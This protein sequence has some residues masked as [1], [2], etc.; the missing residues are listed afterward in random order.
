MCS[1]VTMKLKNEKMT[2]SQSK[3]EPR[4]TT[5]T[6]PLGS[7]WNFIN[8]ENLNSVKES[9]RDGVFASMVTCVS[10][11]KTATRALTVQSLRMTSAL[12]RKQVEMEKVAQ[13]VKQKGMRKWIQSLT[14]DSPD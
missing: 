10:T 5:A 8:P 6:L 13:Q 11:A 12:A 7:L 4:S 9:V 14:T 3:S 2:Q 1:N